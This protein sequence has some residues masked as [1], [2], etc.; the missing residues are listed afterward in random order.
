MMVLVDSTVN[1]EKFGVKIFSLAQST[2]KIKLT[3]NFQ[4]YFIKA[5]RVNLRYEKSCNMHAKALLLT[6]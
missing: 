2:M 6:G 5:A 4:H 1:R 3:K